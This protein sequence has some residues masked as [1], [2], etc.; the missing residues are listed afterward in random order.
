MKQRFQ[1]LNDPRFHLV[2]GVTQ[3][4]SYG[5]SPKLVRLNR[6]GFTLVPGLK[7][8]TPVYPG[9][10]L[11]EHPATSSLPSTAKSAKSRNA[12]Y[13]WPPPPLPR[14]PQKWSPWTCSGRG[15]KAMSWPSL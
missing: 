6:E 11:G 13:S 1:I 9:M 8:K 2:Y 4:F 14:T 10:L 12:A 3:R 5:P 7:R 15:W